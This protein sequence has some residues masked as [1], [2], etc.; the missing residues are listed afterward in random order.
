MSGFAAT[1][2]WGWG[3]HFQ[4]RTSFSHKMPAFNIFIFF[5]P[6]AVALST[7][8]FLVGGLLLACIIHVTRDERLRSSTTIKLSFVE[9]VKLRDVV[10][11]LAH[12]RGVPSS[13][14]YIFAP[15]FSLL[16]NM[17]L[18]RQFIIAD[19]KL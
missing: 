18:S 2:N 16:C 5:R 13:V 3:Q 10:L 19:E 11:M 7:H 17:R 1:R 12:A 8:P 15:F 9:E 4:E 14:F 6:L